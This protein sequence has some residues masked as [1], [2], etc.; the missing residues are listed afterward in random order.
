MKKFFILFVVLLISAVGASPYWTL[1]Q[2]KNAYENKDTDTIIGYIAFSPLQQNL[3][4]QLA[5]V[6]YQ[7]AQPLTQLP[8]LKAFNIE[9]NSQAMIDKMLNQSIEKT[10][11]ANN[12]KLLL[13]N[14]S[15]I[16]QNTKILG[17]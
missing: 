1:Y 12:V 14:T 13:N 4:Q 11:T 8:I 2:L 16:D 9:I 5:P 17:A 7:K 10:I 3:K 15:D 6:L